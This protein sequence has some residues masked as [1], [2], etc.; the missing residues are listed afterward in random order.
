MRDE[1]N[2]DRKL[3][4]KKEKNIIRNYNKEM[5]VRYL[6]T[7]LI[8]VRI[9]TLLTIKVFASL[10]TKQEYMYRKEFMYNLSKCL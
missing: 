5:L 9:L 8:L 10:E 7:E 6:N 1:S 2:F 4:I 3:D